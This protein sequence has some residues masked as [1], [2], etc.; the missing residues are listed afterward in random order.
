MCAS[1]ALPTSADVLLDTSAAV[2]LV[3]P[4]EHDVSPLKE[5]THG[6]TLGLAG[7]AQFETYSVLTRLPGALRVSAPM[8]ARIIASNFP[9]SHLLSPSTASTALSDLM[10]AQIMGGAVYDG[11]VALAARESGVV[12]LS[13]DRRAIGTYAMLGV[14]FELF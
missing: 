7:H 13:C 1:Y 2:R 14:P 9:A 5:R 3:T 6:L 4:S 10:G 8:A 12:L 11:L